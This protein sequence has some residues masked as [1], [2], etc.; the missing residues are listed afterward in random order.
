LPK[1][2][3]PLSK[4]AEFERERHSFRSNDGLVLVGDAQG[5]ASAPA[6][7]L[8]HGGGQTRHAWRGTAQA[9]AAAGFYALAVDQRG[10]GESDWS[11]EGRYDL[12]SFADDL[13][14]VARSF[15][16]RPAVVG[17]SLGGLAS[18]L[19][20][21][22]A[23]APLL[24]ALVLVDVAPRLELA[25]VARI[26]GFM[27][28]HPDGFASM[29]EAEAAVAAYL[30]HRPR[31]KDSSGLAKNL[32]RGSDGRYR[33]HWDPRFV[34]RDHGITPEQFADR[35]QRAAH[36]LRVPTLLVR[37]RSSDVLSEEGSRQ[38]MELVPHAK[39]VDVANAAH[40]VAGDRND[41]FTDV[42]VEFLQQ[43]RSACAG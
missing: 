11:P 3:S 31:P 5:D 36:A 42:V 32:R 25:G 24:S 29:E 10:H 17:A 20:E 12:D 38:F 39:F 6:V 1:S 16:D 40:M 30:P 23:E 2:A 21:G 13:R 37:G 26:I 15:P 43:A 7:V 22:E 28:A 9:L 14:V 33:W 35:M 19:A 27:T 8:L 4:G 34:T 18:L 41:V